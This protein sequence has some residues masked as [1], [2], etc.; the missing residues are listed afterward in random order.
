MF[1]CIQTVFDCVFP[2]WVEEEEEEEEEFSMLFLY[3][4]DAEDFI[5]MK[6]K[7]KMEKVS[8]TCNTNNRFYCIYVETLMF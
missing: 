2:A 7:K 1:H 6:G 8:S 4:S 3:R 5:F